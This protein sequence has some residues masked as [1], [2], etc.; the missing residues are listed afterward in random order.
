M[1]GLQ[2]AYARRGVKLEQDESPA[3]GYRSI[4]S[5]RAQA[6]REAVPITKRT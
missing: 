2:A 5:S 1:I 4:S 3:L 6:I